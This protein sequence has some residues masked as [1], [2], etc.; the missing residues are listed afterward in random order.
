MPC[1][2][3]ATYEYGDS[4]T[5]DTVRLCGRHVGANEE[6]YKTAMNK[7]R[8]YAK[9]YLADSTVGSIMTEI[10]CYSE[11][12]REEGR[13]FIEL[14]RKTFISTYYPCHICQ[15]IMASNRELAKHLKSQCTRGKL[16]ERY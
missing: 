16:T 13:R 6:Q 3:K 8:G 7:R 15:A 10:H 12:E 14:A 9:I 2:S 11:E 1:G 5:G 4:V